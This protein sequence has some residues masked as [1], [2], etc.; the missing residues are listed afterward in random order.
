M[1]VFVWQYVKRRDW[2]KWL[3]YVS[4]CVA[5]CEEKRLGE[6]ASVC[7]CLCRSPQREAGDF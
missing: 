3:V 4:V 6:M 1:S 5:V 2:V 7:Q